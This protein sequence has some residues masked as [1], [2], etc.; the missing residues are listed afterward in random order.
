MIT[1]KRKLYVSPDYYKDLTEA[2]KEAL[3]KIRQGLAKKY[4]KERKK[5]IPTADKGDKAYHKLRIKEAEDLARAEKMLRDKSKWGEIDAKL[6]KEKDRISNVDR[7]FETRARIYKEA[8]NKVHLDKK[9]KNE[10]LAKE[11]AREELRV[12]REELRVARERLISD[13]RKKK[14]IKQGLAIGGGIAAVSGASYLAGNAVKKHK[15]SK[16]KEKA[17]ESVLGGNKK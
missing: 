2:E 1:L 4:Y 8:V 6:R 13:L 9:A 15:E 12:A 3:M 16:K 10:L 14:N 11:K 7:S 17:K 5:Y